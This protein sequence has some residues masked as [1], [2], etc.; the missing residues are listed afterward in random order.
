[1][2]VPLPECDEDGVPRCTERC[3]HHDGK[4]C[5]ILGHQPDELC[6]PAVRDMARKLTLAVPSWRRGLTEGS[7]E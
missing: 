5:R 7:S 6:E 1:M 3:P 4:R 2:N